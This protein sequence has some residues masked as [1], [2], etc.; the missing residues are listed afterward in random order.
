VKEKEE[1]APTYTIEDA[2]TDM[3]GFGLFHLINSFVSIL[4]F[5]IGSQFY[6]S[7]PFYQKYP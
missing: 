6:Y 4:H 7:L 1:V 3:G 2:F 5:S